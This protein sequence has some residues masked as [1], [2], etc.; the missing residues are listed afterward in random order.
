MLTYTQQSHTLGTHSLKRG[1]FIMYASVDIEIN[2]SDIFDAI[3]DDLPDIEDLED[4]LSKLEE[5]A[6]DSD[7]SVIHLDRNVQKLAVAL[8]HIKL[9]YNYSHRQLQREIR[10]NR[11]ARYQ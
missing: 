7:V 2:D 3:S 1:D 6:K 8:K 11:Y 10:R 9:N 4:R 5:I